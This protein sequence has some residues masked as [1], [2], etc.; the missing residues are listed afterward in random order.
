MTWSNG[1]AAYAHRVAVNAQTGDVVMHL[2]DNRKCIN[3][4]HLKVGT[5]AENSADMVRKDRQAKGEDCG[6]AKLTEELIVQIRAQQG[7]SPSRKVAAEYGISKT[8]VLDIWTR[9]IWKHV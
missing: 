8:N 6:N 4:A 3:P 5:S 2:C 1:K 9:R 7:L